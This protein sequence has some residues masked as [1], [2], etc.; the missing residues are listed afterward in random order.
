[1]ISQLNLQLPKTLHNQITR[2]AESEGC[3]RFCLK[4]K[5]VLETE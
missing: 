1:M 3:K 4:R 2:L 5:S